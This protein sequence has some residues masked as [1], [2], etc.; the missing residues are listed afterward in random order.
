MDEAPTQDAAQ[1]PK[2]KRR[3]RSVA[4]G[5]WN[6]VKSNRASQALLATVASAVVG[7][8]AVA[9][10]VVPL[11]EV[12]AKVGVESGRI[13]SVLD[14]L[15]AVDG[16]LAAI[17]GTD[18]VGAVA[19]LAPQVKELASQVGDIRDGLGSPTT[20]TTVL[21]GG[22][23]AVLAGVST[24]ATTAPPTFLARLDAAENKL[25]SLSAS[26]AAQKETTASLSS[27]LASVRA[28]L[29][30]VQTDLTAVRTLAQ[31]AKT[32]AANAQAAADA[33]KARLD[34]A[35][36]KLP[37]VL[38][39]PDVSLAPGTNSESAPVTTAI[40]AKAKYL[41]FFQAAP[42]NTDRCQTFFVKHNGGVYASAGAAGIDAKLIVR[43]MELA[44]GN[45]TFSAQYYASPP[46]G[47]NSNCVVV[48]PLFWL[49][50]L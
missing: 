16:A 20:T 29:G 5:G 28:D 33:A 19:A 46:G 1:Q 40:P 14:H 36:A 6:W 11:H 8:L 44:A 17:Q 43:S 15:E 50:K 34:T 49:Q 22:S 47:N 45:H 24:T 25:D 12:E 27:A 23:T 3:V 21:A 26:L 30:A 10:I 32:A 42:N 35:E 31:E 7:G 37:V 9:G 18:P 2:G 38:T 13:D 48:S 39:L 4:S 41:V